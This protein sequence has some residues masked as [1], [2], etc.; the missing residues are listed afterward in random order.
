[1]CDFVNSRKKKCNDPNK[2]R[3][4]KEEIERKKQERKLKKEKCPQSIKK[5]FGLAA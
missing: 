4:R 1:M 2:K 3:A 5:K